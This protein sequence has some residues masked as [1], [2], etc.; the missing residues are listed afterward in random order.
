MKALIKNLR[1]I[2]KNVDINILRSAENVNLN[3]VISYIK[4]G[5]IYHFLDEY[6]KK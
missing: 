5:K 1:K 2:Y 3:T 6:D 4:D